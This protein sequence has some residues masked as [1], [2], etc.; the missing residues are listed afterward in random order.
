ML[1]MAGRRVLVQSVTSAIPTYTMQSILFPD[2]VCAAIDRL[3]RNF[4][5]GS[6]VANRPH[7]VNWHSVCLPRTQGGLG[8][9]SA[10]DNNR[11]LIAK[12]GWQ[13]LSNPEKP[14]CR[15]FIQKY[16]QHGSFM[17]CN[18]NSTSSVTWKSILRCRDVLRLGLRWRVGSGE[19]IRFWQDAWVSDR[20]LLDAALLPVLEDQIDIPVSHVINPDRTWD[21]QVLKQLLPKLV[22]EQ[23]SALPLPSFGHQED[24]MYWAGSHTGVFS[25]KIAFHLLQNQ[26]INIHTHSRNWSWI[27]KLHCVEKIKMFMWLLWRGRLF[28][29][30]LSFELHFA[31]SPLCPRCE[32]DQETP[33]HL[34]R[35]CYYSRLVW[36]FTPLPANFFNLDFDGWL[37]QNATSTSSTGES[38]QLWSMLFLALL[39]YI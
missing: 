33:L 2:Y 37:Y 23:I 17:S 5:W 30:S 29:N 24:G 34:L 26:S 13:L 8:I 20:P 16:L 4:L 10:K 36:E 35:D 18:I 14:W 19:K 21:F 27:W 7:L 38:R 22:V 1:S 31:S 9:R 6:D 3:N 25:V 39:W 12:L 11:A 15:A 28:T 32:Q